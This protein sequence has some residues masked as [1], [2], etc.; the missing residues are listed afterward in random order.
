LPPITTPRHRAIGRGIL[1][2]QPHLAVVEQERVTGP[3]RRQD[4]RMRKLDP[5]VVAGRLVGIE[6]KALP[7]LQLGCAFVEGAKP[8]FWALKIDQDADRPAIATLDIAN[9]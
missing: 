1:G 4:F 2:D 3:Q 6:G 5:A 7:V 8:Q 9:G